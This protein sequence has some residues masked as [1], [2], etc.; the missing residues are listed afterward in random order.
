MRPIVFGLV[1]LMIFFSSCEKE[2]R[3]VFKIESVQI[4]GEIVNY[5]GVYKTGKLTYFDAV[6]RRINDKIFMI[7]SLGKF[8]ISFDLMHP[9]INSIYFDIENESY[10]NFYVEPGKKYNVTIKERKLYFNGETGEINNKITEFKDSL[11]LVF[12]DK[13]AVSN[14]L[15]TK[16]LPIKDFLE[17]QKIIE[18][19]KL[20]FL[21]DFD[22]KYHF[23]ESV[24]EVLKNEIS[25][26]TAHS[27]INYRYDYSSGRPVERDTLPFNF[28]EDMFQ[29]YP[30]TTSEA[31]QSRVSIDYISN[32]VSVLQ[33]KGRTI[34]KRIEFYKTFNIF[35]DKHLEILTK[36]Y[37]GDENILK[38][39][40]FKSF[41]TQENIDIERILSYRYNIHTII[42]NITMLNNQMSRDLVLS[43]S[44][45]KNYFSNNISPTGSE[46]ELLDNLIVDK[47]ILN[48]IK[49]YPSNKSLKSQITD[50]V[51]EDIKKTIKE[52]KGKYIGKYLGKV[53][54]I[55]F[56]ATWC[57]PCRIEIPYAK[58]L[59]YEFKNEDVIFLNLCAQSKKENWKNLLLQKNI[60]GENYLLSNEEYYLL[61]ELYNVKGFPTYV[62]IDKKGQVVNFEAPRPS[63]KRLIIDEI[64]KLLN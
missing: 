25:F 17:E 21:N 19:E 47:Q 51:D 28:Y 2:S 18:F 58:S 56:Y 32:I 12:G 38:S 14:N 1:S 16:G 30:I 64:D 44:I 57:G 15:H 35:S 49:E 29:E 50:V 45:S 54:Y 52:V 48:F 7:D 8:E 42:E 4:E 6:S 10:S 13:I 3:P 27:W 59:H 36:L 63:S 22:K 55:D 11:A 40:A 26:K 43:Q 31:Y 39:N 23:N 34:G 24:L 37:H 5:K 62:L 9:I 33:K 60:K 46:L 41:N 53:I 20:D 61:S